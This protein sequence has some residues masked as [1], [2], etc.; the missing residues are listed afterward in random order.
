M[1]AI[2][3]TGA[4]TYR[5]EENWPT[6]PKDIEIGDAAAVAVDKRDRV[7]LFNRGP[8][9]IIVVDSAGNFLDTWGQDVF[10]G[11]HGLHIGADDCIYCTDWVDHTV[12]KCSLDG[13]VLME[14]GVSNKPGPYMSGKPFNRC[15]HTA[16]SPDLDFLYVTDGYGNAHV[17]K[18]SADGKLLHTWGG[19]GAD[20]G[21]FNL[22]HAICCD[23]DGW[24][25][26]AD[27]E[28]HRIQIFDGNGKYETQINNLHR[29]CGL[30]LSNDESPICY[31]GEIGPYYSF[32]RTAP[33]LGPRISIMT[34]DGKLLGR[35]AGDPPAGNNPGQFLS[36]HGLAVDSRGNLYVGQVGTLSW[37]SLFPGTPVPDNLC[38]VRKLTRIEDGQAKPAS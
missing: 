37:P 17:H 31:V 5:A 3:G 14:F 22:P 2:M 33:N 28:N 9:P 18:F 20:E 26:V 6:L 32:N 12:R 36:P 13:K 8:N 38:R 27:R 34:R 35:L 16:L 23:A 19:S 29:P 21:Q 30:C 25:Y 7:Y 11:A 15:T 1:D 4:Y 24:L 10:S